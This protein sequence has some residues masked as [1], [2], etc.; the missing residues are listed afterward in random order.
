MEDVEAMAGVSQA[1]DV[2]EI[3]MLSVETCVV[4]SQV[5]NAA[6]TTDGVTA[7]P[8]HSILSHIP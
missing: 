4:S 1:E 8:R 3:S 7:T 5:V 6:D 2:D